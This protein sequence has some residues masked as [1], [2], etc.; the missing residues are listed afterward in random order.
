M[1]EFG[2]L[3]YDEF[4]DEEVLQKV[5]IEKSVQ[6]SPPAVDIICKDEM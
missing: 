4:N 1:V 6:L 2:K 5:L 3:P